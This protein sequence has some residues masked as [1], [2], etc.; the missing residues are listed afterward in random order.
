MGKIFEREKEKGHRESSS[1]CWSAAQIPTV[2]GLDQPEARSWELNPALM[3]GL[4]L[5]SLIHALWA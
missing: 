1:M 3:N 5:S 2:A 4:M